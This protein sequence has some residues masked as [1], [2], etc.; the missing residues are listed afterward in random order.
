MT[1]SEE[2]REPSENDNTD[3]EV[4][5]PMD[6]VDVAYLHEFATILRDRVQKM[7]PREMLTAST[8]IFALERLPHMTPGVDISLD[9][10]FY[11]PE[12]GSSWVD[13]EITE[14]E[15]RLGSGMHTYTPDVGGDTESRTDFE[16]QSGGTWYE[17]DTYSWIEQAWGY[18]AEGKISV[19]NNSDYDKVMALMEEEYEI[20]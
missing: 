6:E 15:L 18:A 5:F 19:V 2:T 7:N 3:T 11:D 12:G 16:S 9:L 8:L 1:S 13:L 10:G 20:A 14:D 17:G 4:E